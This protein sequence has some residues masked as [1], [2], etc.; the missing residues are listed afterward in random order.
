M[1]SRCSLCWVETIVEAS[2]NGEAMELVQQVAGEGR[3][4]QLTQALWVTWSAPL[5][6]FAGVAQ[7]QPEAICKEG[8]RCVYR[9][10]CVR[11]GPRWQEPGSMWEE[12][13]G[14]SLRRG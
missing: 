6:S 10:R 14:E 8:A 4:A 7:R 12:A 1:S 9:T 11:A 13:Q 2:G 5:S 3:W